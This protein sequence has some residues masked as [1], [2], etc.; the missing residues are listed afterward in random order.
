[1]WV[2]TN[3]AQFGNLASYAAGGVSEVGL[4]TVGPPARGLAS[5]AQFGNRIYHATG[6]ASEGGLQASRKWGSEQFEPSD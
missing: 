4:L 1:M 2:R 6:D 3:P 5:P